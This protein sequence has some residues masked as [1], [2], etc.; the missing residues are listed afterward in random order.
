M[1]KS[2][3]SS[4]RS[5]IPLL[6]IGISLSACSQPQRPEPPPQIVQCPKPLVDKPLLQPAQRQAGE[7]L[8]KSLPPLSMSAGQTPISSTP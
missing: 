6:W 4:W 3:H 5:A 2:S 1:A 8:L 7:A